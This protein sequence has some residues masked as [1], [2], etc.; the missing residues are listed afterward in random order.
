[1][2]LPLDVHRKL[3]SRARVSRQVQQPGGWLSGNAPPMPS[4][5]AENSAGAGMAAGA[6]RAR[7]GGRGG[8]GAR[9]GGRGGG[10]SAG[11]EGGGAGGGGGVGGPGVVGGGWVRPPLGVVGGGWWRPPTTVGG[12]VGLGT[13]VS[14]SRVRRS[15]RPA[16]KAGPWS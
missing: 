2:S 5:V 3:P 1:M 6:G 9:R 13:V 7:P 8:G 12:P 14:P 4:Y 11:A 10:S 16:Q 15:V